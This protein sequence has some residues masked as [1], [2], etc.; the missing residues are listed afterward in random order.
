[1]KMNRIVFAAVVVMVVALVSCGGGGGG[2]GL[3]SE[4][5]AGD[6]ANYTSP[7]VTS[8]NDAIEL[9][10]WLYSGEGG[11][12][13]T[14][15]LSKA[16]YNARDKSLKAIGYDTYGALMLEAYTKQSISISIDYVDDEDFPAVSGEGDNKKSLTAKFSGS[17]T[18]SAE[19]SQT[20]LAKSYFFD[21]YGDGVKGEWLIGSGSYDKTV[22]VK[23]AA[24]LPY[25]S[26]GTRVVGKAAVSVEL[27]GDYWQKDTLDRTAYADDT[28]Y[29]VSGERVTT[30]TSGSSTTSIVLMIDDGV[31]GA[32]FIYTAAT[33]GDE[34][35]SRSRAT[36][37]TES[38]I[39]SDITVTDNDGKELFTLRG[40]YRI[41]GS[42]VSAVSG[43]LF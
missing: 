11:R 6:I 31:K 43:D 19:T 2:F 41:F 17:E 27:T 23:D 7:T 21:G 22:T 29:E 18:S 1:M 36:N 12:D 35:S 42:I 34:E 16:D 32:K 20:T 3:P 25:T 26:G 4:L 38:S 5:D 33:D 39:S 10:G 14:T 15:L 13:F 37:K 9:L 40:G 24:T 8:E 30:E 28:P